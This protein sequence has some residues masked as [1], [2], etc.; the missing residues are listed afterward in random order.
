MRE[1]MQEEAG[2]REVRWHPE[3][4]YWC[5]YDIDMP[6][7]LPLYAERRL[8]D[9]HVIARDEIA[10]KMGRGEHAGSRIQGQMFFSSGW[11]WGYW[12]ND[13]ICARSSWQPFMDEPDDREAFRKALWWVVRPFGEKAEQVRDL[14]MK[15]IDAQR[16][17]L[18]HGRINGTEPSQVDKRNGQAYLVGWD[19]MDDLGDLLG[20]IPGVKAIRT[21]P[22]RL[23]PVWLYN[24]SEENPSYSEVEPLLAE[25]ESRFASLANEFDADRW[26]IPLSASPFYNEMCDAMRVTALRATQVHGLY[27]YVFRSNM[28]KQ[29]RMVRLEAARRALDSAL[30]VVRRRERSYR[31]DPERIAGWRYN[32]TSYQFGYLWTVRT[33]WY[34]WRDEGKAVDQPLRPGYMNILDTVDVALGEGMVNDIARFLRALGDLIGPGLFEGFGAPTKEPTIPPYNLRGRP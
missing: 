11:E 34:W 28:P 2:A 25:L 7:F 18:I 14:L 13:V 21:N 33:L 22:N 3:T 26:G 30:V 16:E 32:P 1:F 29:W 27:D 20:L 4:A 9:L 23:Q 19:S 24:L 31:V 5:T 12:L 6:L 17:L 10:G 8:Y 15:T